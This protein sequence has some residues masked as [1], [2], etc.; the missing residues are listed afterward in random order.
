MVGADNRGRATGKAYE[1]S[2]LQLR[3]VK[4]LCLL[5]HVIG[6]VLCAAT[7]IFKMLNKYRPESKEAKLERLKKEAESKTPAAK[8]KDQSVK[9]G[10]NHIARLVESKKATMVIIAHDVSSVVTSSF[11][12]WTWSNL[13][14]L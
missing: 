7:D 5:G 6:L 9:C 13:W 10:I 8:S 1:L 2:K 11:V 4:C 3:F 14:R 12:S